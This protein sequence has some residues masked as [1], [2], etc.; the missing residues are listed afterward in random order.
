MAKVGVRIVPR[1][2]VTN[3]D[4]MIVSFLGQIAT[5]RRYMGKELVAVGMVED[6]NV[7]LLGR[8]MIIYRNVTSCN[9]VMGIISNRLVAFLRIVGL[10]IS[11]LIIDRW[12]PRMEI[13]G[14]FLS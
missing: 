6:V 3:P 10:R 14:S 13:L 1:K 5:Y 11:I 2:E 8:G 4:V 7:M 12:E 9:L